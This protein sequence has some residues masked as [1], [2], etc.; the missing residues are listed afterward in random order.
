MSEAIQKFEA[1]VD[2]ILSV[3]GTEEITIQELIEQASSYLS[4]LTPAEQEAASIYLT[5]AI[6]YIAEGFDEEE[7]EEESDEE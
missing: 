2:E 5:G 3:F 6:S 4:T 1:N 7:E